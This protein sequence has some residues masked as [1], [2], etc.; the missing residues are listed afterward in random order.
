M[1]T[2]YSYGACIHFPPS[3]VYTHSLV[4]GYARQAATCIPKNA[5]FS[6]LLTTFIL[7]GLG[8]DSESNWFPWAASELRKREHEVIVPDF[9]N[10]TSPTFE[11]WSKHLDQW[12]ERISEQTIFLDHSLGCP[13]GLKYLASRGK[14]IAH[15]VL[16]AAPFTDLGWPE[17]KNMF[18]DFPP[19]DA[20]KTASVFTILGSDNDPYIPVEHFRK[21]GELLDVA[22]T[23]LPNREHLWQAQLPEVLE[24]VKESPLIRR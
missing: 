20:K 13:F 8:A 17:L 6:S 1:G 7:H 23:I 22:A 15:F 19:K 16:V 5:T 21:Y 12:G 9:P 24:L 11:A 3:P 2:F 18:Q 4:N 14:K 10:A